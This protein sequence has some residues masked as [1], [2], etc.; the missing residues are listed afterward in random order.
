MAQKAR[1]EVY[2]DGSVIVSN[3]RNNLGVPIIGLDN[4]LTATRVTQWWDGTNM[5]ESKVDN[6]LYIQLKALPSGSDSELEQYI[7]DYFKVNLPN[8]GELFLEKDTMAE[9]R[10]LSPVEILLLRSGYYRGVK[11]NGYYAKGDTPGPIEYLLSTT[12]DADD[13]GS[14]IETG[15]IK[16][17]HEFVGE[18]NIKYFGALGNNDDDDTLSIQNAS[19]YCTRNVLKQPVLKFPFSNGYLTS[20]GI[21]IYNNVS[22]VMESPIVYSGLMDR[23]ALTIGR[24]VA[25]S[26][27]AVYSLRVTTST[28]ARSDWSDV[29][30]YIGIKLIN[31]YECDISVHQSTYFTKTFVLTGNT[32]GCAYNTIILGE[33]GHA[34]EQISIESNDSG[35]SNSNTFIGG[36]LWVATNIGR[37][38]QTRYGIVLRSNDGYL[39]N[40]NVFH[41]TSIELRRDALTDGAEAIPTL[42]ENGRQNDFSKIR[43]EGNT[44]TLISR[45]DS[46]ANKTTPLFTTPFG[47]YRNKVRDEGFFPTTVFKNNSHL[48]QEELGWLV[49]TSE[50]LR[51][52]L[53]MGS[54]T[55][56]S[57]YGDL[58]L[59]PTA[60]SVPSA[61]VTGI[62]LNENSVSIP[63]NVGVGVQVDT[64][65]RKR[66]NIAIDY[67]G[68]AAGR[69]YIVCR[70]AD[71]QII[72]TLGTVRISPRYGDTN[73]NDYGVSVSSFFGGSFAI[74]TGNHPDRDLGAIMQ[75]IVLTEEIKEIQLFIV[76]YQ[77]P[78]LIKSFQV[79]S[80][81]GQASIIPYRQLIHKVSSVSPSGSP[82][83]SG[84]FVVSTTGTRLGWKGVGSQWI[85]I[86]A[87]ASFSQAGVVKQTAITNDIT[88]ADATDEA[89]AIALANANKAKI[90]ELLAKMRTAGIIVTP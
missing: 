36:R 40:N 15:G 62:G 6:Q 28:D 27:K 38:A 17:Y 45:N 56:V 37:N 16:L 41:G 68:E 88:T 24:D 49:Y 12:S 81:D 19:N 39:Q 42:V 52:R 63:T 43:D 71:G 84:D 31:A 90:N 25:N 85:E 67:E 34:F 51:N 60:N 26:F 57:S 89:T 77:T 73:I 44:V 65:R 78:A 79:Q 9:M 22:V 82:D 59:Q 2:D 8:D 10:G 3:L 46:F 14:V 55:G 30:Q 74:P 23:T 7:G 18:I 54:S 32:R 5:D 86:G 53:F 80:L 83:F 75:Y 69:L 64:T 72:N 70:D 61:I 48:P 47:T 50:S 87:N 20:D 76:G 1:I 4:N 11:L 13:G 29:D 21:T 33:L 66:F 35:W 58:A